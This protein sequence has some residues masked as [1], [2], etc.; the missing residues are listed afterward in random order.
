VSR[1]RRVSPYEGLLVVAKPAGLTSHDVVGR[2]RRLAG[3]RRVGHA[4]T[5][6]P[7][8][9]GVLV[10]GIERATR[11]L[12]L[13][14]LRDKAYV[15]TVRLGV[16]TDTDD[17]Q[18]R[19]VSVRPAAHLSAGD[20]ATAV[21]GFVGPLDQVPSTYSAVKIDGVRSYAR[22]RAGETVELAARR[23]AV[24]RLDL[25]AVRLDRPGGVVDIDLAV[26]CST[27]TYVRALARDIGAMLEVGGHLTALHRTRV[28][29]YAEGDAH[30]LDELTELAAA[31]RFGA[32]VAPLSD[33]VAAAFPRR[34][35]DAAAADVL[36]HGGPLPPSG[37]TGPVGVFGPDGAVLALVSD[38]DGV[39]RPLVVF[40]PR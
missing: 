14:S 3:T 40:A 7:M 21:A 8:A 1:S 32:A 6:D 26:E 37:S 16:A 5:L 20:I 9:T 29:P 28:G 15:A 36:G 23:V 24:T 19:V 2:V 27:G 4:G 22:A 25:T 39:A 31:G 13:L 33:A 34:E 12:G 18:G 30:D 11:L 17:A 10:V 38:R 35:V